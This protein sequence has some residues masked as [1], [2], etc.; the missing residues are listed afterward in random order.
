MEL[1]DGDFL[2][3]TELAAIIGK[4]RQAVSDM[5]KKGRLTMNHG[6]IVVDE[7]LKN[8]IDKSKRRGVK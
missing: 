5:V 1:K 3:Q 4:S 2:R 8:Y 7:A 6:L